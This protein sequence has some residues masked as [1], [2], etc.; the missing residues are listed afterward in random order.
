[1]SKKFHPQSHGDPDPDIEQFLRRDSGSDFWKAEASGH[2]YN[3]KFDDN[4]GTSGKRDSYGVDGWDDNSSFTPEAPSWQGDRD[5]IHERLS[6]LIDN[7]ADL[8]SGKML[9]GGGPVSDNKHGGVGHGKPRFAPK[10]AQVRNRESRGGVD[11]SG[12]R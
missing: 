10:S 12:R 1:M 2:G 4:G 11:R 6:A 5:G 7:Q 3:A 9:P 8:P